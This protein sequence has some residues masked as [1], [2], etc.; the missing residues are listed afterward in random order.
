MQHWRSVHH[1]LQYRIGETRIAEIVQALG[2]AFVHGIIGPGR[3]H[4]TRPKI[5]SVYV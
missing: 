4:W 2:V 1:D 5:R 3:F